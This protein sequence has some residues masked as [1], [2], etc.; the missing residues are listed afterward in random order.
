MLM[1][2]IALTMK[3]KAK[4]ELTELRARFGTNMNYSIAPHVTLTYPFTPKTDIR[5]IQNKLKGKLP[6]K[7]GLSHWCSKAS[8]IGKGGTTWLMWRYG[9]NYLSTTCTQR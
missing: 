2:A 1:Y 5:I 8:G 7:P 3:G 4:I 9:I 6:P